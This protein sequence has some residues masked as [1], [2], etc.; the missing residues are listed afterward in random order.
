[1]CYTHYSGSVQEKAKF[2]N[3]SVILRYKHSGYV[4]SHITLHGDPPRLVASR[5]QNVSFPRFRGFF[6]NSAGCF[7]LFLPIL[8]S[9]TRGLGFE[10][11]EDQISGIFFACL[12]NVKYRW[13]V[14][15]FQS[16]A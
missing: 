7:R 11:T 12:V 14:L 6:V 15:A 10:V 5:T 9:S 2:L 13:E 8:L 1:M 4:Q 3:H 16:D